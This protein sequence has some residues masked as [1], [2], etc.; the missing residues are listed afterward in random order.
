[1][2]PWKVTCAFL[3]NLKPDLFV[4]GERFYLDAGVCRPDFL[5]PSEEKFSPINII[6]LLVDRS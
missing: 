3:F 6:G 5:D 1:M 2:Q 4:C